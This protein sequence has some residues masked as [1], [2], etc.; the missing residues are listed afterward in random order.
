MD[1]RK[2]TLTWWWLSLFRRRR[3][4][5]PDDVGVSQGRG[6]GRDVLDRPFGPRVEGAAQGL[7]VAQGT[8]RASLPAT[9]PAPRG[10]LT[11]TYGFTSGN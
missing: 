2:T 8:H 7:Q 4:R 10:N 1:T 11:A 6:R 5:R 3:Q 9:T